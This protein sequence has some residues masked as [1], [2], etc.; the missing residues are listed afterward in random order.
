MLEQLQSEQVSL[1]QY[2]SSVITSTAPLLPG[3]L[4]KQLTW[5]TSD[6]ERLGAGGSS[7]AAHLAV[8]MELVSAVV[9]L[10][11]T[12]RGIAGDKDTLTEV[13]MHVLCTVHVYMYNVQCMYIS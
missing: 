10:M 8:A 6:G 12:Q 11:G 13:C 7:V 4:N 3:Y 1:D 2:C 9:E 5:T